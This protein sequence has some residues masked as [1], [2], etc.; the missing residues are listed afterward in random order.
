M[1]S[2]VV[3]CSRNRVIGLK[4]RIPWYIPADLRRFRSLTLGHPVI[5]GRK[6]FEAIP[7]TVRPLPHRLNIVLTSRPDYKVPAG[8]ILSPSLP[9][10][11]ERAGPGCFVIGGEGPFRRAIP[12][13][14]RIYLTALEMECEGDTYFPELGPEWVCSEESVCDTPSTLDFGARFLT[15]DR[16][17]DGF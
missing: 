6:T 2:L 14:Q 11:L 4:G 8:V 17:C 5:M 3:A 13:A 12:L 7:L 16:R 10:A 1:I 15:Y 9:D